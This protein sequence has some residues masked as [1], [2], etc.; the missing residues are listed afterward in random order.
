MEFFGVK[1]IYNAYCKGIEKTHIRKSLSF[2]L[3][4][5]FRFD[6]DVLRS[7]TIILVGW[8]EKG[9]SKLYVLMLS[10]LASKG[11]T[12]KTYKITPKH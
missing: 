12:L 4:S 2:S 9:C 10:M 1:L 11:Q 7:K 3:H 8:Y 6:Q 5:L